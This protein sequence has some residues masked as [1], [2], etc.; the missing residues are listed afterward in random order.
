MCEQ[1]DCIRNLRAFLIGHLD[2]LE[3]QELN[4][5]SDSFQEL[6]LNIT[7]EMGR[8]IEAFRIQQPELAIGST[9]ELLKECIKFALLAY[10]SV[11]KTIMV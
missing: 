9:K 5:N 11:D 4:Y 2:R 6:V 3:E 7:A 8:T 1:K 10:S